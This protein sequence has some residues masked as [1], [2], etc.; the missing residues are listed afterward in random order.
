MRQSTVGEWRSRFLSKRLEDKSELRG[1]TVVT[2][3]LG[4]PKRCHASASHHPPPASCIV[5]VTYRLGG[6]ICLTGTRLLYRQARYGA[7]CYAIEVMD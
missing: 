3:T 5:Q 6:M 7:L 1:P 4:G 2:Q